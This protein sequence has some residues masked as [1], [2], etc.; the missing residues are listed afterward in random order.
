VVK[1]CASIFAEPIKTNLVE[2]LVQ[3][4]VEGVAGSRWQLASVPQRL[5]PLPLLPRAHRHNFNSKVET[6]SGKDGF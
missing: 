5:L 6:F 3:T 1:A 2:N 4:V